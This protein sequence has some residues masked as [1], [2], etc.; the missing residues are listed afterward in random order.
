M[1]IIV[2]TITAIIFIITIFRFINKVKLIIDY[3]FVLSILLGKRYVLV[4]QF[5]L[6]KLII[7]INLRK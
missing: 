2:E 7:N 4:D 3:E 1:A 6:I 5:L